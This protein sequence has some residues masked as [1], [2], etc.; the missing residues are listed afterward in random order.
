MLPLLLT[1]FFTSA[2]CSTSRKGRDTYLA[3]YKDSHGGSVNVIDKGTQIDRGPLPS[4]P[5]GF[6]APQNPYPGPVQNYGPPQQNYG[7]PRPPVYQPPQPTYGPPIQPFYGPPPQPVYGPPQP[8]YGPP[9]IHVY[10]PPPPPPSNGHSPVHVHNY[11]P[12]VNFPKTYGLSGLIEKFKLKLN[13]LTILKILLK[14]A[15]F[16]KL[17]AFM[18]I[19]FLLLFIPWIKDHAIHPTENNGGN[20][21]D[22]IDEPDEMMEYKKFSN[23]PSDFYLNNLAGYVHEALDKFGKINNRDKN[24]ESIYCKVIKI[25]DG[26]NQTNSSAKLAKAYL[27]EE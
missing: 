18:G 5:S 24:C 7:P 11:P 3:A 10:G 4:G 12:Q 8:V 16:K 19:I 6:G 25:G 1:L 26:I 27:Q 14:I 23:Q 9:Q 22:I 21:G 17:V 2:R 13:I 20:G 15:L